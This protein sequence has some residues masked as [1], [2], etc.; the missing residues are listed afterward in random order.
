MIFCLPIVA[1]VEVY[2]RYPIDRVIGN[3][4]NS[5]EETPEENP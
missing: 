4:G 1:N 2:F 3:K 5:E